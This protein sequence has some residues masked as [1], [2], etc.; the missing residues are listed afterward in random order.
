[1]K[2]VLALVLAVL[3]LA[4]MA[5]CG[6][7]DSKSTS[8]EGTKAAESTTK[9]AEATTKAA[10]ATTAAENQEPDVISMLV[11]DSADATLTNDLPIVKAIEEAT[12]VHFD[13]ILG[14]SATAQY[15]EKFN[16]IIASGKLPDLIVYT[17]GESMMKCAADG[18]FRPIDDLL[19]KMPNLSALMEER[20]IIKQSITADDG[21]AYFFPFIGS[22]KAFL[23]WMIREDWLE[24]LGLDV[25]ETLDEW[26]EV[27]KAF[28]EQDANGNGDPNDEI[29]YASR[30]GLNGAVNW[31]EAFGVSQ[32]GSQFFVEDD[33]TVIYP[34]LDERA[35]AGLEF[36]NKLYTEGLIDPE[37][38]SLGT[39][40]WVTKTS[41]DLVG[42]SWDTTA[43]AYSAS[44][45]VRITTGKEDARYIVV[46][47]PIGPDGDQ[48]TTHQMQVVRGYTAVS[49]NTKVADAIARVV[50]FMYSQEG[51]MLNNWGV[52]GVTYEIGADGEPYYLPEIANDSQGRGI[53]SMLNIYGHREWCYQQDIRYENA[54]LDAEYSAMRDNTEKYIHKILPTLVFTEDEQERYSELKTDIQTYKDETV[55]AFIQGRKSF[56]EYDEFVE[57]LKSMGVEEM[58]QIQQDAY[59][60]FL[61]R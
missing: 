19:E 58:V 37:Y 3:M 12:N 1:M 13:F 7:S 28:K 32:V 44:S 2:R 5:A 45:M 31:M 52:E 4:S 10:E 34:Y 53:L 26:Y 55:H 51:F 18:L 40:E 46:A 57:T 61:A 24:N 17:N 39:D 30:Q 27:M 54:L 21:C 11:P 14:P 29:P 20:P 9:A 23:V 41:N 35:K 6:G 50:D 38:A 48:M 36:I 56:D 25:P 43:R 15:T 60:R 16:T 42:I 22:I 33:D 47:P 49:A 8:A 59:N